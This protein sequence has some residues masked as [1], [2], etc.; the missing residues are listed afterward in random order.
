MLG[1]EEILEILRSV[2][3][4]CCLFM[5]I[6]FLSVGIAPVPVTAVH[7]FTVHRMQH[8]DLHGVR[9]GNFTTKIFFL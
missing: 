4:P 5:S 9:Y 7:E 6:V 8:F 1:V 3:V 2:P